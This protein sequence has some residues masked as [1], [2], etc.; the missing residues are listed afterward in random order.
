M[1]VTVPESDLFDVDATDPGRADKQ[2]LQKQL[3]HVEPLATDELYAALVLPRLWVLYM[4]ALRT[5]GAGEARLAGEF[6]DLSF[7]NKAYSSGM[8]SYEEFEDARRLLGLR[9]DA[10]HMGEPPVGRDDC[11]RLKAMVYGLLD[12]LSADRKAA[13]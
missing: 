3:S 4:S 7:L 10:V 12:R 9:N 2:M 1:L 13:Q 6:S 11:T 5:L 8:I